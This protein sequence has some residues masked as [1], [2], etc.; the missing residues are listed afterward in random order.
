VSHLPNLLLIVGAALAIVGGFLP[1]VVFGDFVS[2]QYSGLV[3]RFDPVFLFYDNGGLLVVILSILV[4]GVALIPP[5]K[6]QKAAIMIG[7]ICLAMVVAYQ[8]I[9]LTIGKMRWANNPGVPE[10]LNGLKVIAL[11][12]VLVLV[13]AIWNYRI[14]PET[15]EL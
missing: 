3:V 6:Y 4:I 12:A 5:F 8:W 13:A 7:A 10:P 15:A 14:R 11:G 9:D 1:W 2:L